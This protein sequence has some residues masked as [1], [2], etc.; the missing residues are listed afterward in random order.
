[1]SEDVTEI[2]A[3]GTDLRIQATSTTPATFAQTGTTVTV[4]LEDHGLTVGAPITIASAT[5]GTGCVGFQKVATV[6]SA[7]T[8][9]FV[10]DAAAG[11]PVE[12]GAAMTVHLFLELNPKNFSGPSGSSSVIDATTLR[13]TSKEKRQGLPDQGQLSFNINYVPGDAGAE[14]L[15][16]HRANRTAAV[17]SLG[18]TDPN[19]TTWFHRVFVLG[20]SVTG[21]VDGLVEAQVTNEITGDI[22]EV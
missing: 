3:Q 2:E 6:P 17:I 8:F 11:S 5:G 22:I 21:Q 7:D 14:A 10:A 16:T 20:F 4:T 15:R 1:V 19:R 18:F 12:A 9:T 13:S